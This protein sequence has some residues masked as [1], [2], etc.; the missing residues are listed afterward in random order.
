MELSIYQII[1]QPVVSEKAY[2]LNKFM[3]QLVFLVH[4]EANKPQIKQ[5]VEQL[6]Q[7]KV[8]SVRTSIRGGK[9]RRVKKSR[10]KGIDT[11]R[12]FVSL[13]DGHE[14]NLLSQ[15]GESMDAVPSKVNQSTLSSS[16]SV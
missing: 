4:I 8:K 9:Y 3:K 5:A 15:V 7:V 16:E 2:E 12:A 14:L 13:E 6:F 1:V 11:K 10:V